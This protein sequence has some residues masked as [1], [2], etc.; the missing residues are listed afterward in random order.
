MEPLT[1]ASYAYALLMNE[2]S[3]FLLLVW[4]ALYMVEEGAERR[5]MKNARHA[6][7]RKGADSRSNG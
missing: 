2:A 6:R 4:A 7:G 1:I 3:L 5:R